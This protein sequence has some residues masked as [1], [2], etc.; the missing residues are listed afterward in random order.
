MCR[1]LC[2]PVFP[3][4]M[5]S[6]NLT[7]SSGVWWRSG[8]TARCLSLAVAALLSVDGRDVSSSAWSSA[9]QLVF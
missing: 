1:G 3:L 6:G 7:A 4:G 9:L 5:Q 2:G 8:F